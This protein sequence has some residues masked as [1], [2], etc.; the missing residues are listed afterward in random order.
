[1]MNDVG[2]ACSFCCRW[3]CPCLLTNPHLLPFLSIRLP[4][5][6]IFIDHA[7]LWNLVLGYYLW[8]W[9]Y[10]V[11]YDSSNT[12]GRIDPSRSTQSRSRRS[13]NS[14]HSKTV[15]HLALCTWCSLLV[16]QQQ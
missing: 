3:W 9:L 13:T 14:I 7:S 8:I 4:N 11:Q 12:L 1:M 15:S 10:L 2:D 5:L 16:L 6:Y